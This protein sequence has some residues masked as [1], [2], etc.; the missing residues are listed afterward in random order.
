MGS[1]GSFHASIAGLGLIARY[2]RDPLIR[3]SHP[4]FRV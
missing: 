1:R 4:E 3:A 2:A